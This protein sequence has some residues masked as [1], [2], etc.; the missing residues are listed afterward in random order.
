MSVPAPRDAASVRSRSDSTS[1]RETARLLAR[2]LEEGLSRLHGRAVRIRGLRREVLASSSSFRTERLRVKLDSGKP[3]RVF[4]KDLHPDHL[5]AKARTV[6]AFDLEPSWRELQVY[7]SILSAERFGTLQLYAYRWEPERGRIW[8]F[9]EDGGHALLRNSLDLAN[10]AAA[11]RWAARFH[12]ATRD[13]PAGH[14]KF[15]PSYDEPHY[16]RCA[17]QVERILLDVEGV[18]RALLERGLAVFVHDIARLVALPRCVIHGQFFGQNI[19]LRRGVVATGTTPSPVVI[20]WETA[21]IGPGHFD[22]ASLSAGKWTEDQR[23]VMWTAYVEQYEAETGQRLDGET[24][25]QD[26]RCVAVYLCLEWLVW[27]SGHR[28][29]SRDFARFLRDLDGLLAARDAAAEAR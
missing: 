16:R 20:D 27:W 13:L 14:T 25:R 5:M 22:L 7:Q 8:V 21:A 3:L 19:L 6:R 26:L 12:A 10:W 9:L 11:A 23:E 15:L 17:R 2:T 4:F 29:V 1:R 18:E 24:W 28:R